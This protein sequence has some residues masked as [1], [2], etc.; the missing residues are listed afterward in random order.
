MATAYASGTK[1]P[2][3]AFGGVK[4]ERSTVDGAT[5][6]LEVEQTIAR[7]PRHDVD[8]GRTRL[9][10]R[11][12]ATKA[13]LFDETFNELWECLGYNPRTRRYL[14]ISKNEH[15]VKVTLRG[16]VYVDENKAAFIDS[17][18]GKDQFHA[19]SSL[20]EPTGGI[21]ALIGW[22]DTE[23][24]RNAPV[25]LYAFDTTTDVLVELGPPPAPPPL[26][27]E[28]LKYPMA[29]EMLGPWIAPERHYTELDPTIWRF[30]SPT[31]LE[32]SYGRDTFRKRSPRRTI[33]RFDLT[34]QADSAK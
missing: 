26:T 18:F 15:G 24:G 21:L 33:K 5:T 10:L 16:L 31:T 20:Y 22:K 2:Y 32:V 3:L 8:L 6:T 30:T 34:Q 28:D 9:L 19:V 14:I 11:N 1:V 25:R 13:V 29:R 17:V 4:V 7:V 12:R 27:A 23:T